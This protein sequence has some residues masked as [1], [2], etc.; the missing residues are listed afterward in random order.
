[1]VV[2]SWTDLQGHHHMLTTLKSMPRLELSI[3]PSQKLWKSH[4]LFFDLHGSGLPFPHSFPYM[5]DLLV[6]LR[7]MK[8]LCCSPGMRSV[9][10]II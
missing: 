6:R 7:K 4:L 9:F 5:Y 10:L 1:M 8:G 3:V 2:Y